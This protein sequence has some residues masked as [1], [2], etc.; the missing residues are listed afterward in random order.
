M[1]SE[2]ES[3][4]VEVEGVW[5]AVLGDYDPEV[6]G[7]VPPFVTGADVNVVP[8]RTTQQLCDQSLVPYKSVAFLKVDGTDTTVCPECIRIKQLVAE[9]GTNHEEVVDES[10]SNGIGHALGAA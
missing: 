2:Q 7:W 10:A 4:C 3:F 9:F 5:H 8:V 1:K 6:D